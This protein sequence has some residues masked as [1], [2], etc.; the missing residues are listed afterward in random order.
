[1][2]PSNHLEQEIAVIALA[3]PVSIPHARQFVCEQTRHLDDADLS[4]TLELLV[5]EIV[6]N[7]ILHSP[8]PRN[9]RLVLDNTR[10]TS[11]SRTVASGRLA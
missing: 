5:S 11:R 8:A 10:C 7:A 4:A 1:M 9:L 2:T 6:T 3:D